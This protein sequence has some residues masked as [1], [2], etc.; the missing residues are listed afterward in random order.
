MVSKEEEVELLRYLNSLKVE[1][2]DHFLLKVEIGGSILIYNNEEDVAFI[3]KATLGLK[4][5]DRVIDITEID[6]FL[7]KFET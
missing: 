5:L 3:Y 2:F 7:I 1:E 6:D 4:R